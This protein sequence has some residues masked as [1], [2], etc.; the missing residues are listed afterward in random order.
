M[1][2]KKDFISEF[3]THK[4]MRDVVRKV[5]GLAKHILKNLH[6]LNDKKRAFPRSE[7]FEKSRKNSSMSSH[8]IVSIS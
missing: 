4:C 3:F 7:F 1:L 5:K 6:D 2:N 8:R